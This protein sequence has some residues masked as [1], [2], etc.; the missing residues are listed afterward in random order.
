MQATR[1]DKYY[2]HGCSFSGKLAVIDYSGE[3]KNHPRQGQF[4]GMAFVDVAEEAAKFA[5]E[6]YPGCKVLLS[7]PELVVRIE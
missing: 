3:L 4:G 6:R 5:Q 7:V 2:K 1:V